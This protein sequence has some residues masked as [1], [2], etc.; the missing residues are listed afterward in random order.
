MLF[1]P[2]NLGI[3]SCLFISRLDVIDECYLNFTFYS[4]SQLM[5]TYVEVGEELMP[6]RCQAQMPNSSKPDEPSRKHQQTGPTTPIRKLSRNRGLVL[7]EQTVGEESPDS[8]L[9]IV[10]DSPLCEDD[11]QRSATLRK[12]KRKL[13]S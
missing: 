13:R 1:F 6:H 4:I 8:E 3:F 11:A 10:E 9:A 2:D 7:Q 5:S 12:G